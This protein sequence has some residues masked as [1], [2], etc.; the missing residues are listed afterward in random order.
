MDLQAQSETRTR[1]IKLDTI[2]TNVRIRIQATPPYLPMMEYRETKGLS[3]GMSP[4][5]RFKSE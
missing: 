1:D 4:Q 5:V 3:L 2:R